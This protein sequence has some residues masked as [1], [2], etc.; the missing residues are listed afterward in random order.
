[1]HI[2][3]RTNRP[4]WLCAS[5]CRPTAVVVWL[6]VALAA[7]CTTAPRA[8]QLL[9]SVVARVAGVAITRTDVEAAVALGAVQ[10]PAGEEPLAAGTRELIDRHLL[11]AEVAR[12]PPAEPPAA[13]IAE[14]VAA[15]KARA[16]TGYD[17]LV[18]RTGLDDERV[19][20]MARD[21][22]RIEA[23]VAQRFGR[24]E[25]AQRRDAM[26][27]Q[28]LADLRLRGDVVEVTPRR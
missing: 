10:V 6:V 22:L 17:E 18:R 2:Q 12:F 8:S 27:A 7:M 3:L 13:A 24:A 14:R 23:Y 1:M 25:S 20:E 11:L 26:L 15:M 21:S 9:D 16:G 5:V 28:W 4:L 19:R